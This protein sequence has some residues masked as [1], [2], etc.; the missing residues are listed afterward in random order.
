MDTTSRLQPDGAVDD[1]ELAARAKTGDE[2]AMAELLERHF[3]YVHRLC[4]RMLLNPADAENARQDALLQI[5]R[6]IAT[7]DGRSTFRVWAHAVT[8]NVCLNAIRDVRRRDVPVDV[9][10]LPESDVVLTRNPAT[11]VAIRVDVETALNSLAPPFRDVVVLYFFGDL[12]YDDIA[13]M[14][15]IKRDTVATRLHRGKK[16]LKELLGERSTPVAV[17]KNQR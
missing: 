6:K 15:N 11:T 4:R 8:R 10:E 9:D 12:R 16:A 5:A 3:D 7:F 13:T 17:S 2:R 14:L 1:S